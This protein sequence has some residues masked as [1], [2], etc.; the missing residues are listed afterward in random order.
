[1]SLAQA[2]AVLGIAVNSVRSRYKA[3]KIRGE[4]DNEGR[5]W[6]WIDPHLAH[7][8]NPSKSP[9][10]K[11]SME[12][13]NTPQVEALQAHISTL[14]E[15]LSG[16]NSELATLRPK[17]AERDRLEAEAEGL[18]AQLDLLRSDRDEWRKVAHAGLERRS[19]G[20]LG[21][22]RARPKV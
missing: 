16:A 6:V 14:K 13:S 5:I 17:A 11:S 19:G 15:Q 1:M 22:F 7:S 3:G 10:S 21:L 8:N 18:R 20:L 9:A 12:G 4:R 2:S